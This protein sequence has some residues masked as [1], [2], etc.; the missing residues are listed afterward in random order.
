MESAEE[1]DTD[2]GENDLSDV[3]M[4]LDLGEGS[5]NSDT[6]DS[7][8]DSVISTPEYVINTPDMFTALEEA[9]EEFNFAVETFDWENFEQDIECLNN[10]D[11]SDFW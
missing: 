6:E 2:F 8:V 9:V 11:F 3:V 5:M 10:M 7:G 1:S 4:E